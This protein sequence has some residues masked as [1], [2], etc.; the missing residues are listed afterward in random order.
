MLLIVAEWLSEY[1]KAFQ[2]FQYLTFRA[3]LS[4]LT[5]LFLALIFG[6]KM[7]QTL[8]KYQIGQSV[9]NDGPKSHLSKSGTPTMGGALILLSIGTS[10]LLW[11]DLSNRFVWVVMF[12]MVM[13]GA[14][15][16]V[17]D[18]RK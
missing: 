9:R 8:V 3:I 13:F 10:T 11:A 6:P 12:V 16:W 14:I 17:D 1:I 2:V 7:I 4:A 18:Y 15:G 5:A